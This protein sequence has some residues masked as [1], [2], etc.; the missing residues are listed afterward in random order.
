MSR[1]NGFPVA[2]HNDSLRFGIEIVLACSAS[3]GAVWATEQQQ[4]AG[5]I[6]NSI[7]RTAG[8][9]YMCPI[10]EKVEAY[11]ALRCVVDG[12]RGSSKISL[13]YAIIC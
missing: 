12:I 9:F 13:E 2:A 5:N 6:L 1:V 8:V 7:E 11:V 10:C 3:D 4:S